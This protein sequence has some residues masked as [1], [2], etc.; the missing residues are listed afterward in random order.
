MFKK[1]TPRYSVFGKKKLKTFSLTIKVC[2]FLEYIAAALETT[3]SSVIETLIVKFMEK[4]EKK[5]MQILPREFLEGK[6]TE[7]F[8]DAT[9]D[10]KNKNKTNFGKR[11]RL[12][13]LLSLDDDSDPF[14]MRIDIDDE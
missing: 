2:L 14:D 11:S 6:A 1:K 7:A 5:F 12:K 4:H 9:A 13:K 3:Q 8:L 10:D